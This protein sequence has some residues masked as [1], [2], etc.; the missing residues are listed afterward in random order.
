MSAMSICVPE[1]AL[2]HA[3]PLVVTP[4]RLT[5]VPTPVDLMDEAPAAPEPLAGPGCHVVNVE[6]DLVTEM[7]RWVERYVQGALEIVA[8]ERPVAQLTRW[9]RLTVHQDLARR[10][11][12]VTRARGGRPRSPLP[13]EARAHVHKV[14][15]SFV[16]RNVV[17]AAVQVR[18]GARFRAVA[19]RFAWRRGRWV[20]DALEFC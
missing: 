16:Q 11:Q 17:E 18:Q 19:G 13:D 12:L 14:H 1:H 10:A 4:A 3:R 5:S 9:T 6:A 15:V 20:C 7:G 2:V 8:G